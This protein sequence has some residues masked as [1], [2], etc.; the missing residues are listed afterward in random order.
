M[1][2]TLIERGRS[3]GF[4]MLVFPSSWT[5]QGA[6]E[7][8]HPLARTTT[9]V[10]PAAVLSV[11]SQIPKVKEQARHAASRLNKGDRDRARR[12]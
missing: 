1:Q 5:D 11:A 6:R 2:T 10:F 4:E 8:S 9:P 3:I 12:P 7:G